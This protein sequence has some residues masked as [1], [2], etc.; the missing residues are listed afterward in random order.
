MQLPQGVKDRIQE[1][2][3]KIQEEGNPFAEELKVMYWFHMYA[4]EQVLK[5]GG[6]R[7]GT[8]SARR[9]PTV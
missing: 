7:S 4:H 8:R 3:E 1:T 6:S 9:K 2:V 5:M